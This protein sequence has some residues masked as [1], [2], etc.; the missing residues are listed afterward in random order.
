LFPHQMA[1][2]F[3]NDETLIDL[4]VDGM[5]IVMCVFPIVGFQ[6]VISHFF[7][8]IGKASKAIFISATRQLLFLIPLLLIL[9]AYWGTMG[10][11]V[12][13]PVS[14]V[15]SAITAGIFFYFEFKMFKK[16]SI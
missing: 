2:L 16:I 9:P 13:M 12:S 8:S 5:R 10:V 6:M 7:Q 11:W 4:A 1:M 15:A 14:D 3:T